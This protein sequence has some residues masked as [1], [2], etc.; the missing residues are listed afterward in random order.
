M[1]HKGKVKEMHFQHLPYKN[2]QLDAAIKKVV[3]P[4]NVCCFPEKKS[5]RDSK[6]TRKEKAAQWAAQQIQYGIDIYFLIGSSHCL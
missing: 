1:Q 2:M 5:S 3:Q 4:K 6:D